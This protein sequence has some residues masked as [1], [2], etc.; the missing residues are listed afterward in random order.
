MRLALIAIYALAIF[1]SCSSPKEPKHSQTIVKLNIC[2]EPNTLDPRKARDL[3]SMSVARM[4]FDGLTRIGKQEKAE[5]ALASSVTISSDVKKYTFHLRECKWSNGDPVTARDFVHAWKKVLDPKFPADAAFQLYVI[6]NAK[7][8]KEG[9]VSL[10]ELGVRIVNDKTLEVELE[11]AVPYFLELVALPIFF[12]VHET[13]DQKNSQWADSPATFV[14]NGPFQ[15]AEWKHHDVITVKKNPL[16]WDAASVQ[17]TVIELTMVSD[18]AELKMYEKKELDWAGSPLSTLPVEAIHAFKNDKSF[19]TKE[20][21][22]TYF[23]RVNT[24]H[25]PLQ[26]PSIR[27][28][29]ALAINRQAIVDHVTQG[30]Q[31]PACGLVPLSFGLQQAPYFQD[32]AVEEAKKLFTQALSDLHMTR[33]KFPQFTLIYSSNERNHLIAQALEQQWFQALGIRVKL[34]GI[35]RSVYFDRMS[36]LDYQLA[37]S[38]WVADFNDPINFLEVFKYKRSGSNNTQWENARY[39]ELL[40]QSSMVIHANERLNLLKMSEQLLIEEMPILPIFYYTMLY[41]QDPQLHDVVL[42]SMGSVDFKWAYKGGN[43][44]QVIVQGEK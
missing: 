17:L 40:S 16:Y 3:N 6:K 21:L 25:G 42:S 14:S 24:E 2:D 27:K 32:G 44:S 19:K 22:G 12:P 29:L 13:T 33:E 41:L 15:L 26:H 23:I 11:Y 5:L 18:D 9:K 28:A 8:V 31:I 36:K 43:H 35:E 10:D 7:A 1:T 39:A 4:L 34:E 38:S 37:S 20:L 30:N